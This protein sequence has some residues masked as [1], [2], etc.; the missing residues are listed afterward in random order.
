MRADLDDLVLF[1]E[2]HGIA[3]LILGKSDLIE[4]FIVHKVIELTVIIQIAH[5]HTIDSRCREFFGRAERFFQ[6]GA[7]DNV[8]VFCSYKR[9]AFSGFDMLKLNDLANIAVNL[10]CNAIF[11]IAC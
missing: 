10:E 5:I 11:K 3:D 1:Y 6:H 7:C 4:C 8:F 2:L 9:S